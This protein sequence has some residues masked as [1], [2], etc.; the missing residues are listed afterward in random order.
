MLCP[1][2]GQ[3]EMWDNRFDK[4]NPKG[5]D[6]KCKDPA[7]AHA[8]WIEK[9]K[10]VVKTAGGPGM[11]GE[12]PARQAKWTWSTLSQTY[13]QS[14]IVARKSV[15]GL[16]AATKLEVTMEHLLSATACIFIEA[17]RSGVQVPQPEPEPEEAEV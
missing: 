15:I 13:Q 8:I 9:K 3:S 1:K 16:G 11:P 6:Y 2:C 17:C 5:P 14:L 12:S 4:K 7:C 10:S